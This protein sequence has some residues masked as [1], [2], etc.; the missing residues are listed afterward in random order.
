MC[1]AAALSSLSFRVSLASKTVLSIANSSPP[2][3]NEL[4]TFTRTLAHDV[5]PDRDS[6]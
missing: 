3:R 5:C 1:V 2:R 4:D 6:P